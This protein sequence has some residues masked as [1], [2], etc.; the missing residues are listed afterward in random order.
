MLKCMLPACKPNSGEAVCF[1]WKAQMTGQHQFS[2]KSENRFRPHYVMWS[3]QKAF[4]YFFFNGKTA[5]N[6]TRLPHY[7]RFKITLRHT[8][9]D[10]TRLDGWSARLK[11]PLPDNAQH[12][13]ETVIYASGG[14]WTHN[15]SKRATADPHLRPRGHWDWPF[16]YYFLNNA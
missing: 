11:R 15:P 10:R 6:G 5:P 4:F 2:W 3:P 12:S 14:I 9:L 7:R 1:T 13:Q 8:T 16:F